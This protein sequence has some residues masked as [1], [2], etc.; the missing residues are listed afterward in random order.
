MA[1]ETTR[2]LIDGQLCE[3]E[4]GK[5]YP[6][7]SPWN[8]K[9]IGEAADASL[10]DM[11]RAIA[12]ARRA[13]DETDWSTNHAG[14]I[15][16][17]RKYA[18]VLQ[19]N[20][21]RFVDLAR[22]EVGAP[23][24]TVPIA[25]CDMPLAMIDGF[26]DVAEN[27]EWEED[28]GT[29]SLFGFESRRKVW[30]EAVGV[31]AAITP[32]NVPTQINIAKVLPAL[33]AGCTVVLK[34]APETPMLAALMGELAVEAGLPAG[35]LN[36]ITAA[37]AVATGEMLVNDPRVDAISFTGST[38]TGKRIM[39]D[40]AKRVA[41]V[42]LELGGKSASIVLDD[43]P[44]FT[45]AVGGA[46]MVTF[47][48]GQGCATLTRLL[49]PKARYDE[50][51]AI[52][53]AAFESI[54]YGDPDSPMQIM[55][56]LISKK[57]QDRVLE[58]I[59]IGKAEGARLVTG[60]KIPEGRTEGFFVEPT[61]FADVTNN[62]R[63]AREEIFGPVLVVIPF[64][65]DEDAIRIANDS[66]YGLSGA[67][68]SS[69]MERAMNVA[70]RV[71]TGTMSV[72]GGM[73]Y[74]GDAPFGGYKQSGIGREMGRMGFEEYLETKTVALPEALADSGAG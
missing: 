39:A 18:R 68:H 65:N 44:D 9:E 25:A 56:S 63:I 59:E 66:E 7:I 1:Y 20:R 43:A 67:V 53:K 36:V 23:G 30:K 52:L 57:Q 38:Q 14:R 62:M 27:Y 46:A 12:A 48:A 4:N 28:I 72:N 35:V 55:G 11:E 60:G 26:L 29:A 40:A 19:D 50:A 49:V 70:R 22:D 41:R 32:W 17:L 16:A 74:A 71:R 64:E 10:A 15:A 5:T 58:Y 24:A 45:A 69:S 73:W 8:G 61:L 2:L 51:T 37:D 54:E 13:F 31:V 6:D 33:A 34:P 47:H 42:F 21:Q 3:A